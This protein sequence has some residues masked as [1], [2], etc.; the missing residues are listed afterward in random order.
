MKTPFIYSQNKNQLS[1]F[2]SP[3]Y[4]IT[5]KSQSSYPSIHTHKTTYPHPSKPPTLPNRPRRPLRPL[6]RKH[7]Q[8]FSRRRQKSRRSRSNSWSSSTDFLARSSG[9]TTTFSFPFYKDFRYSSS[10]RRERCNFYSCCLE[11]YEWF[12]VVIFLIVLIEG[13]GGTGAGSSRVFV[14]SRVL[15]YVGIILT[16]T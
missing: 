15:S 6:R 7:R 3:M 5:P 2:I 4:T 1:L 9:N 8:S 13:G 11:D 10:S 12:F 16:C 14:N